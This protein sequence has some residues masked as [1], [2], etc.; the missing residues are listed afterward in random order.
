[1]LYRRIRH[2]GLA[3]RQFSNKGAG[4]RYPTSALISMEIRSSMPDVNVSLIINR[5]IQANETVPYLSA[6]FY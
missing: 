1:M 4:Y 3:L 2:I 5:S 6:G